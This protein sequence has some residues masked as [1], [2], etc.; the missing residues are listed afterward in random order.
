MFINKIGSYHTENGLNNQDYGFELGKLKCVVDG[1]SDGLHSEVG[2]KLF[3]REFIKTTEIQSAVEN[4]I[5][6]LEL[7]ARE[8][9]EY[10]CFTILQVYEVNNEFKTFYCGD[11]YIITQKHDGVIDFIK[12][13]PENNTPEYLAYNYVDKKHLTN[14]QNGIEIK[15]L[16]FHKND[17]K[18]IGVA[19]DGIRY[20]IGQ[21]FEQ[22]L[23]NYLRDGKESAI[24]R[25][26][27]REHKHLK[28]DITI[29]F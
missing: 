5:K 23:K 16:T 28:D 4:I 18:N 3:C 25:L 15:T 8:I 6:T 27:N 12:L 26:I 17:Y 21:P 20:M 29:A 19:T 11:G 2:A 1:C 14:F 7:T 10:L 9:K 13:E 22:E 24:K